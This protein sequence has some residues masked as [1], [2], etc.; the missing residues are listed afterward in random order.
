MSFRTGVKYVFVPDAKEKWLPAELITEDVVAGHTVRVVG[1]TRT[2]TLSPA[3]SELASPCGQNMARDVENLV[4]LEELS[5]GMVLY[6]VRERFH[7]DSIYTLVGS[8][9]VAVNPFQALPIY[10]RA[11]MDMYRHRVHDPTLPPP[12]IFLTAAQAYDA[13]SQVR[14]SQSV[15]ISGESGAGKTETTKHVLRYIAHVA[16]PAASGSKQIGLEEQILQASETHGGGIDSRCMTRLLGA[17]AVESRAGGVRQRENA[18]EQQ[19]ITVWQVH[20]DRVHR[21]VH[22]PRL[23]DL[24]L[25]AREEPRH[26]ADSQRA[27][28][29]R[30]LPADHRIE[31]G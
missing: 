29:S 14:A 7:R 30:V 19:L 16:K 11:S 22:D 25:P 24:E 17:R 15:L 10:E 5:E 6:H 21:R 23:L 1:E 13:I 4:E 8:I 18:P 9:L 31:G 28:L 12:H 20:E 2:R 26:R 3:E 27:Q